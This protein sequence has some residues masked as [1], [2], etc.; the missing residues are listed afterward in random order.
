MEDLKQAGLMLAPVAIAT[1]LAVV[2][3]LVTVWVERRF[4]R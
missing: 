1:V 2:W 3:A 4:K